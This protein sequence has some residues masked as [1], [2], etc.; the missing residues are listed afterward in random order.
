MMVHIGFL[1]LGTGVTID[2]DTVKP[3]SDNQSCGFSKVVIL[4]R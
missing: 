4:D 2:D 1:N 3:V